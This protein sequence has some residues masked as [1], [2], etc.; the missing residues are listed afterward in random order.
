MKVVDLTPRAPEQVWESESDRYE[1]LLERDC[2]GD[3]LELDDMAWM[4]Y[5]EKTKE[6][7]MFKDRFEF[8]RELYIAGPAD[9][10][11]AGN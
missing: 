4:R 7:K 3:E 9:A 6:Y 10:E 1:V 11:R 5:Y 8:L 2:K